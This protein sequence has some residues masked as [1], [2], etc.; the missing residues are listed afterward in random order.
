MR[1]FPL[2]KVRGASATLVAAAFAT[3]IA[4]AAPAQP[5]APSKTEPS[6]AAL[7]LEGI[8]SGRGSL[9]SYRGTATL[10]AYGDVEGS[11]NAAFARALPDRG[12]LELSTPLTGTALVVTAAGGELLAFYPLDETAVVGSD[13]ARGIPALAAGAGGGLS[14]SLDL[15]AGRPPLYAEKVAAGDLEIKAAEDSDTLT[16]T[17]LEAGG[18]RLQQ[19]T[20][21]GNPRRPVAFRIFEKDAAAVDVT[22]GDW[23]DRGDVAAPFAVTVK[24]SDAIVEISVKKFEAN[25]DIPEEAFSTTPPEGVEI[26]EG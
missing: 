8:E 12:R 4:A 13:D 5:P 17:W 20:L 1:R 22:Y 16:L 3:I 7:L 14:D 24:T 23:R 21:A 10:R 11:F 19:L 15:L 9:A 6:A 2:I 18:S 25:V 26:L